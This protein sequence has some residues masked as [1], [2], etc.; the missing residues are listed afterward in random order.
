MMPV[1]KHSCFGKMTCDVGWD[2]GDFLFTQYDID[3]STAFRSLG[4]RNSVLLKELRTIPGSVILFSCV[5]KQGIMNNKL[6]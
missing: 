4:G 5:S 6:S 3:I 2:C 1:H